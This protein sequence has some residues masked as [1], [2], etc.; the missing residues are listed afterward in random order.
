MPP[1]GIRDY[2]AGNIISEQALPIEAKQTAILASALPVIGPVVRG[3][4]SVVYGAEAFSELGN[5]LPLPSRLALATPNGVTVAGVL[6]AAPAIAV[7]GISAGV[8]TAAAG[9]ILPPDDFTSLSFVR[10]ADGKD[11][12]PKVNSAPKERI[13]RTKEDVINHFNE[14]KKDG[15]WRFNNEDKTYV[16]ETSGEKRWADYLHNEIECNEGNKAWVIDPVTGKVLDK[17]GHLLK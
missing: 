13:Q 3:V 16:N 6:E 4:N 2:H 17:K 10:K 14:L 8:V 9:N 11:H 5:N 15:S 12:T 1:D 7:E